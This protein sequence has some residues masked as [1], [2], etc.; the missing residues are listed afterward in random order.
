MVFSEEPQTQLEPKDQYNHCKIKYKTAEKSTIYLELK[1]GDAIVASGVYDVSSASE[2]TVQIPLKTDHI[3]KLEPGS[4][5]S[6]NLYMYLGG[7]NDWTR[8]ACRSAHI[9]N[10]Q[11]QKGVLP[12]KSKM[13]SF[14][15]FFK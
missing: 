5:Y 10:V 15:S 7:R 13:A 9:N 2:Q 14:R 11:M 8:K 6:Y 4:N 3:Q 1:R 12:K